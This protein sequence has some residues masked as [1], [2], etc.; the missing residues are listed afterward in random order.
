MKMQSSLVVTLCLSVATTLCAQDAKKLDQVR[1]LH[2][3]YVKAQD[4]AQ[5]VMKDLSPKLRA[6]E[7]GSDEQK[8]L[9]EQMTAARQQA[10]APHKEFTAAFLASDWRGFDAKKDAALLK[11]GLPEI[12]DDLKKPEVAISA[13]QYYLQHF[14]DDRRADSIRTHS[15]PM[16]LL[17]A[18]KA[19]DACTMLE[20]AAGKA[21]GAAKARILLTIGDIAAAS[22]NVESAKQN[23]ADAEAAADE[24]TMGYVT[25]RKE[26]IG[27]PAPDIAS[28]QWI[29]ADAKPLSG[30]KGNVVLVDFWAT[31]CG[32]CRAVMPALNEMY[33]QH[34]KDGLEVVGVTRFYANGYMPANKEQMSSGGESVKDM[35]EQ[36][37][38]EH[39]ATFKKNAGI[40]YPFVIGQEQNFKDYFVK[41]IPTLA[42]LDRE[43]KVALITVGSGSEGLLQFAVSR[44]L[45]AK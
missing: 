12:I 5:E 34:H 29:G 24:R 7:R 40:E 28:Q 19:G 37:F 33:H 8:K 4:A 1:T 36:T 32:P 39:V 31:W 45:A 22:G 30:L 41:G 2:A 6:A 25:L 21:E 23:Y 14:G 26:L 15:M 11:E 10:I 27:K 3:T 43:G 20:E 42:V 17:A 18:G 38:P 16:A 13:A 9:M 35:T 44:L